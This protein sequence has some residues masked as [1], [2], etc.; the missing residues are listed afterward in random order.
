MLCQW[1]LFTGAA[2]ALRSQRG[3]CG[4]WGEDPW[5]AVSRCEMSNAGVDDFYGSRM[6]SG[7]AG[8][9]ARRVLFHPL[10]LSVLHLAGAHNPAAA[11]A[12]KYCDLLF[13]N[14]SPGGVSTLASE[15]RI[16]VKGSGPEFGMPVPDLCLGVVV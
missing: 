5:Y 11:C 4:C 7:D 1:E 10:L 9:A 14:V 2:A 12:P 6:K 15:L 16:A 8:S 3:A 13:V